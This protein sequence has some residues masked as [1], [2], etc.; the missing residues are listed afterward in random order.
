MASWYTEGTEVVF[1][2]GGGIYLSAT[3]AATAAN[4]KVIGV[5]VDQHDE[6][7]DTIIT[8]AMKGLTSS[9][10]LTLDAIKNN[11]GKLPEDK[12]GKTITLGA[13]NDGVGL[14]TADASWG[15]KT[16][17]IDEYNTLF[18]ALVD[19]SVVVSN[20]TENRPEVEIAVDYQS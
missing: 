10:V 6:S 13:S 4:A 17:T 19:G 5:D 3:A 14:P 11:G 15:F 9:V 12:A 2:C 20:D 1:S 16:F 18:G 7:P 8:S